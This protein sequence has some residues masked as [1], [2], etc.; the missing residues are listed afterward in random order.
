M[1]PR[2]SPHNFEGSVA[3]R[4]GQFHEVLAGSTH[5]YREGTPGQ[6]PREK[7]SSLRPH[8]SRGFVDRARHFGGGGAGHCDAACV[9][10]EAPCKQRCGGIRDVPGEAQV[11][12]HRVRRLGM[13]RHLGGHPSHASQRLLVSMATRRKAAQITQSSQNPCGPSASGRAER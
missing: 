11:S 8:P 1:T 12:L 9:P 3:K 6:S 13:R 4:E 2:V 5:F 10:P 7:V